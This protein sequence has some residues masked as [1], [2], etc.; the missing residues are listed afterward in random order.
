MGIMEK[1]VGGTAAGVVMAL[2][3]CGGAPVRKDVVH[4]AQMR[5]AGP[6][7]V[8]T[9]LVPNSARYRDSERK[10]VQA[11]VGPYSATAI[12]LQGS[13]GKTELGVKASDPIRSLKVRSYVRGGG[14]WLSKDIAAKE[15]GPTFAGS[16]EGLLAPQTLLIDADLIDSKGE[17]GRVSLSEAVRLR[18]E[19][20][21]TEIW[22]PPHAVEGSVA[23]VVARVRE[24]HGDLG[25]QADCVLYEGD[26]E[27][28]RVRGAWVD[29]GG[30]VNCG[31]SPVFDQSGEKRLRVALE[32]LDPG[33]DLEDGNEMSARLKVLE[34]VAAQGL[35]P[36]ARFRD[37][38]F[39][40]SSRRELFLRGEGQAEFGAVPDAASGSSERGWGLS[41]Q[42][43]LF[44]EKES[45]SSQAS[46]LTIDESSDL[47]SIRTSRLEVRHPKGSAC[48]AAWSAVAGALVIACPSSVVLERNP[49]AVTYH[50]D[51]TLKLFAGAD[52]APSYTWN[53]DWAENAASRMQLKSEYEI[54]VKLGGP[55]GTLAKWDLRLDL[56]SSVDMLP[57]AFTCNDHSLKQRSARVCA[58]REAR[59]EK[60]EGATGMGE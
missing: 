60:T 3:G 21:V 48:A 26:T 4:P 33:D 6:A 52:G 49:G 37:E 10:M 32:A 46:E 22:A 24:L 34:Q 54:G 55:S 31:F 16:I 5:E 35:R 23:R 47:A 43:A 12:V 50:S 20:K 53:L 15:G 9:A 7:R 28:D 58:K 13:D 57:G 51:L 44:P 11:V 38:T 41:L 39:A 30:Y 59:A 19:L 29:A 2:I 18:P 42:V 14:P 40:A 36:Y 1:S 25:A 17:K 45:F 27:L 8:E 56:K